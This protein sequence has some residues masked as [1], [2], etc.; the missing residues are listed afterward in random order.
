MA[1]NF[2]NFLLSIGED[3]QQLEDFKKNPQAVMD[4]SGF[5]SC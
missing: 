1:S 3:P 2:T 4:S 5:D